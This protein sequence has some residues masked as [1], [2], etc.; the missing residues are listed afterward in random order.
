MC[1]HEDGSLTCSYDGICGAQMTFSGSSFSSDGPSASSGKVPTILAYQDNVRVPKGKAYSKCLGSIQYCDQGAQAS[2]D[3]PGDLNNKI[4]ACYDMALAS[5]IKSPKT[6]DAVGVQYCGIN[7]T[8]PGQYVVTYSV[9]SVSTTVY[10]YTTVVVVDECLPGS[11]ACADGQCYEGE[12]QPPQTS[13]LI[14]Y[15]YIYICIMIHFKTF[16]RKQK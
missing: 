13:P 16:R 2:L 8:L 1:S 11:L 4:Y 3:S 15:I 12:S 14:I 6:Y 7:T 10:A 9:S 5:G